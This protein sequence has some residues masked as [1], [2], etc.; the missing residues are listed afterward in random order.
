[1]GLLDAILLGAGAGRRFSDSERQKSALPKQFQPLDGIPVFIWSLKTLLAHLPIRTVWMVVPQ[2]AIPLSR[3]ITR[4]YLPAEQRDKVIFIEGGERRQDSS[5]IALSAI[6]NQSPQPQQVLIHDACR[7][8]ISSAMLEK[9]HSLLGTLE[10]A[11]WIP[12]IPVVETLKKVQANRVKE[13]IDRSEVYR[14]QT[15]QLFDFEILQSLFLKL[16]KGSNFSFTDDASVLEHFGKSVGTFPGD[17]RNI[18]LTYEFELDILRSNL[19]DNK[20]KSSCEPE[21]ATTSIV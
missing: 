18:K 14:V 20:R 21:S 7:P 1:M 12:V 3:E 9:L 10:P 16:G 4:N 6:A 5:E 17:E 11:G 8:F 13:T 15:P 19:I 2:G